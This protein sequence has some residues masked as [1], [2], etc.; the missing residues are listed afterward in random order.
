MENLDS[1][2]EKNNTLLTILKFSLPS[3]FGAI[4]ALI[5]VLTDRFFI[6]QVSG[7]TG[8]AAVA[9]IFP[10]IMVINSF[11]FAFSGIAILVG[12]NLGEKKIKESEEIL[13]AGF[14]SLIFTGI[15]ISIFLYTFNIPIL[16]IFGAT[17]TTLKSAIEYTTFLI[18]I[19][20]FQ[21]LLGQN[22]LIRGIGDSITAM[23]LNIFTGIFNVILDYIFIM[24]LGMGIK[25]ASLATFLSTF[26]S[27]IYVIYYFLKSPIIKL[28]RPFFKPKLKITKEIIKMGSP[29][30]YNQ[31]L[32]SS[33]L[34]VT[35]RVAGIYGGD[36][37]TAAIG[38]IS[39]CRGVINTSLLGFNQGTAAIISYA[40]GAK[41]F[42]RVKEV[43]KIQL[44][45]VVV[46]STIL[47]LI[48][49]FNTDFFVSF[50]IKNDIELVRFTSHAMR[51]NLFLMPF[52]GI[53]LAL[54]NFFQS[55]KENKIATNFFVI[56]IVILNI[57]LLYIL[58]YFFKETGVWLAFPISD[59]IVAIAISFLTFKKVKIEFKKFL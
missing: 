58:G 48:L 53:F 22:T 52:T 21:M 9:L 7:R 59:T 39:I 18:P 34:T 36:I 23:S 40:F 4:I 51:L 35:N 54:N 2:F 20:V 10:Y 1:K 3:S 15:F 56:R 57:P 55:I 8:M 31:L 50:F 38:I 11:N 17:T 45:F 19:A 25:G 13:G 16:K 24:K 26:L 27:G 43:L 46:T 5:C 41:N 47:V 12:V 49:I 29:R 30:F 33:V 14:F 6:G 42:N 32:Q 44:L 28:R 37:A